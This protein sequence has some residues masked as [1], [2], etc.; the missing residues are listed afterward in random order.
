MRPTTIGSLIAFTSM[1]AMAAPAVAAAPPPNDAFSDAQAV[2]VGRPYTGSVLEATRE[3][4]E[5]AHAGRGP[6]HSVWFRYRA[7]HTGRLTIDT[8]TSSFDT[9]LAVYR[10]GRLPDLRL[11]ASDD[12]ASPSHDLGSTVRFRARRGQTY[13]IAVDSYSPFV[14]SGDYALWVSDGS[15]AGKGVQLTV[16]D[17]Q[18]LDSVIASGLR[19][20]VSARRLVRV[21]IELRIDR[22]TS[23]RLGLRSRVIGRTRGRVDY[24]ESLPA[25]ITLSGEA[26]RA[27]RGVDDV[28]TTVR[29]ELLRTSAPNRVLTVRVPLARP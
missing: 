12:D 1:L 18:T 8:G 5:P 16:N 2:T 27:L 21:G 6:F 3:L 20:N 25:V 10:G 17:G 24:G 9:T 15:I 26:R 7:R 11:V 28:T 29:L 22:R 19:M 23:R 4:G 14:G 13:K